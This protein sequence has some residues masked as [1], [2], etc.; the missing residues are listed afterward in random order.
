MAYGRIIPGLEIHGVPAPYGVVNERAVRAGAGLMFA[1]GFFTAITVFYERDFLFAFIVVFLFWVDFLLKT[2]IGPQASYFGM[3]GKWLTK[4]QRPEYVGAIQKRF[5]WSIGVGIS[6][7]VLLI[8]GY[9]VFFTATCIPV[10]FGLSTLCLISM[11]LCGICLIFMWLESV[12]G[13]CVGC[14]I[15]Q[16]F[17]D[18][19]VMK[20]EEFSPVCP[21]GVCDAE[22]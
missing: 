12:V 14:A 1:I 2:I 4:N 11:G 6:S 22:E 21:G 7:I 3:I 20:Q 5:A 10:A 17:V 8:L 18:K 9:Q 13:F 15:Y 19:G 16:W